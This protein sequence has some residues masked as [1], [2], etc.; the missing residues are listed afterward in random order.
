MSDIDEWVRVMSRLRDE[1]EARTVRIHN[2]AVATQISIK[3]AM[4]VMAALV[5]VLVAVGVANVMSKKTVVVLST[6]VTVTHP[7]AAPMPM[8]NGGEGAR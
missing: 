2:D 6:P 1:A 7:A 4:W 5:A 8:D 3:R